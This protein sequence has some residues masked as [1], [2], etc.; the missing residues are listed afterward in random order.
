MGV[1]GLQTN[2]LVYFQ[3]VGFA[4][5][6]AALSASAFGVGSFSS[7]FLWGFISIATRC[8]C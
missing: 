7:R 8:A 1:T 6:T 3:D 5:T 2:W 4:S